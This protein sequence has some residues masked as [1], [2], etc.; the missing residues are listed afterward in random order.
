MSPCLWYYGHMYD[1]CVVCSQLLR[2][3]C[4]RL[5][6]SC[7][8]G[9]EILPHRSQRLTCQHIVSLIHKWPWSSAVAPDEGSLY[10]WVSKLG[11]RHPVKA[12]AEAMEKFHPESFK[13]IWRRFGQSVC[14]RGNNHHLSP[15]TGDMEAVGFAPKWD[16][17]LNSGLSTEVVKTIFNSRAPF[18]R[19]L[20]AWRLFTLWCRERQLLQSWVPSGLFF[21]CSIPLHFKGLRGWFIG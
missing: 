20:Y 10:P 4:E 15:L 11:S 12:R 16:Q 19:K 18:T 8:S 1:L 9:A 3:N 7:I 14:I 2:V 13:I 21:C 5:P 6:L 17:L